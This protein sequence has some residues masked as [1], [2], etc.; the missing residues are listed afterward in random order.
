M[1]LAVS[2]ARTL[3]RRGVRGS[4]RLLSLFEHLGMLDRVVQYE[5]AGAI[6]FDVPLFLY[7]WSRFDVENYESKLISAFCERLG[8]LSN[9]VFFDCGADIGTF[10]VLTCSRISNLSRIIA[11]E[12]NLK[13]SEFLKRNLSRLPIATELEVK[14]V[15]SSNGTGRL[16]SPDYDGT[17]HGRFLAPGS[18]PV[19]VITIDSLGVRGGD[20]AFKLDVEGG[21]IDVLKGASETIRSARNCVLT[22]EAHPSVARRTNRDPIECLQ[23]LQSLRPFSFSVAETGHTPSLSDPVIAHGE[24][25]IVNIVGWSQAPK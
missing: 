8:S 25:M 23:F 24:T 21:E 16:Q 2:F 15:G 13:T 5:L 10:S 4:Q 19:E 3:A 22:L 11:F 9:V 17:D 12:P 18:G 14:A 20:L 7:L 1:P 6:K